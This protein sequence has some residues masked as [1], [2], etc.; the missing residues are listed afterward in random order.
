MNPNPV[1]MSGASEGHR[2]PG[3]VLCGEDSPQAVVRVAS[4]PK[5]RVVRVIDMPA[6]PAYYRVIWNDHVA[7]LSDLSRADQHLCMDAVVAVER[8]MREHLKPTKINLAAFGTMVPHLHW[9]LI[10]RDPADAHF[11]QAIWAPVQREAGAAFH[12]DAARLDAA[13]EAAVRSLVTS[14]T[15]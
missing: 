11:P 2:V 3:C 4:L 9:H 1:A 7:E 15:P 5:F 12:F 6:Y 8:V 14:G 13:V 10:A